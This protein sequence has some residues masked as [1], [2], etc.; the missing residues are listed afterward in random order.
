MVDFDL[1]SYTV[2]YLKNAHQE[3]SEIRR[4]VNE[5]STD[6]KTLHRMCHSLKGQSFFVGF[7]DIG[8]KALELETYFRSQLEGDQNKEINV[9]KVLG[10]IDL[11]LTKKS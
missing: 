9:E 11:M 3:I 5:G 6:I 7:N 4:F 1:K 10:E 8:L 2:L